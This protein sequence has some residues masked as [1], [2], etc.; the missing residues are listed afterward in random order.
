MCS[1]V[2]KT[3]SREKGVGIGFHWYVKGMDVSRLGYLPVHA[4]CRELLHARANG[5]A[6]MKLW[7]MAHFLTAKFTP[8]RSCLL[9][10]PPHTGTHFSPVWSTSF[11]GW[12]GM[13]KVTLRD[14]TYSERPV[15]T[16]ILEYFQSLH[17]GCRLL[18]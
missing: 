13:A 4:I 17:L 14:Y 18:I 12:L 7:L 6:V 9:F 16:E 10:P 1:V 2:N 8:T 3:L 11:K 5:R 15:S